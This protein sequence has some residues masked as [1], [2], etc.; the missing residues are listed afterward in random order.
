MVVQPFNP[1]NLEGR[2]K[3]ISAASSRQ[4]G[5]HNET[6]QK[7]K[8]NKQN[9]SHN[10]GSG[11]MAQLL[12][13]AALAEVLSSVPNTHIMARC[14]SSSK[15][16]QPPSRL[17]RH[18]HTRTCTHTHRRVR[19]DKQSYILTNTNKKCNKWERGTRN[20]IQGF[21]AH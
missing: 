4:P 5:L 2:G 10:D 6:C 21:N 12:V 17:S 9:K 8:Q 7:S 13:L 1:R 20:R 18:L 19:T 3:W 11:E 16:I 14:N 15:G